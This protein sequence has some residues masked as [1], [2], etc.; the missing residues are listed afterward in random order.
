LINNGST[1]VVVNPCLVSTLS[2]RHPF[3]K[4]FCPLC[5]FRL[6]RSSHTKKTVP[7]CCYSTSALVG[8]IERAAAATPLPVIAT[9]LHLCDRQ[10]SIL[11]KTSKRWI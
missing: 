7:N 11:T 2:S 8:L 3:Q 10:M 6:K 5:A 4:A 9:I 1:D